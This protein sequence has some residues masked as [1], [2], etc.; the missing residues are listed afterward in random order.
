LR[1]CQKA[2]GAFGS[3]EQQVEVERNV[4]NSRLTACTLY[5][6]TFADSRGGGS[7]GGRGFPASRLGL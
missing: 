6:G 2:A 5:Y 4:V 1:R 3:G 7:I